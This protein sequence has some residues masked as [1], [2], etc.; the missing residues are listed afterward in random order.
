M[1]IDS[2]FE[3]L[4]A[5]VPDRDDLVAEVWHDDAQFAE[6]RR[7]GDYFLVE[8]YP[9]PK[10]KLWTFKYPELIRALNAAEGMLRGRVD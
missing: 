2:G 6:V 9:N 8:V 5:S 4:L 10:G 7:E 1:M 3:I